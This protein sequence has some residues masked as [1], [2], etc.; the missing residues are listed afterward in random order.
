MS[1]RPREIVRE[2]KITTQTSY[3]VIYD[4]YLLLAWKGQDR[5]F[6]EP[7]NLLKSIDL[8]SNDLTGEVPK[9]VG[10]LLGLIS[11]N[12]SRNN[13]HGE[14]PSGIGNLNSLEFLD[15]SRNNFSGNIPSTLSNIDSLGVLDLSNNNLSGRIPPG[16]HFETFDASC[17]EGN[18]GLCGKQLNKSCPGDKT[19]QKPQEPTIN[20]Q[21]PTIDGVKD[22]SIFRGALYMSLG[23]GFFAGFWGLFGSMILWQPWRIAYMRFLN[24]LIDYILLMA[25]LNVAKSHR[26]LKG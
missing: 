24:R 20:P 26:W 21:E 17:F 14:I 3:E 13:F 8:S 9:Q 15:L 7:E 18:I 12:L 6:W 4:A 22:N 25:E 16:R 11:L 10:Y 1:V 23:I 2:R 5:E 19:I